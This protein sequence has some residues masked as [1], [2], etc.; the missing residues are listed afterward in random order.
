VE[1]GGD[2]GESS[3]RKNV[4]KEENKGET[5]GGTSIVETFLVGRD[6]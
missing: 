4:V 1:R 5:R 2:G 3:R 6:G